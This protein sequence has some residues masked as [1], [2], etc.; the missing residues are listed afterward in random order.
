MRDGSGVARG[1]ITIGIIQTLLILGRSTYEIS[2]PLRKIAASVVIRL[3]K[4]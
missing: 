1:Q 3:L 2:Y 4:V